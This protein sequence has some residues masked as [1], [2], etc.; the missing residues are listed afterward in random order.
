MKDSRSR[1]HARQTVHLDHDGLGPP[2]GEYPHEG[3]DAAVALH[4]YGP[5]GPFQIGL[6]LVGDVGVGV[7]AGRQTGRRQILPLPRQKFLFQTEYL[8]SR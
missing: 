4:A 3:I 1:R 7:A 8:A 6:D 5:G 2:V